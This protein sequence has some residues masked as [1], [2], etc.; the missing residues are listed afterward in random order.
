MRKRCSSLA[1]FLSTKTCQNVRER[2][3]LTFGTEVEGTKMS[4]EKLSCLKSEQEKPE[5]VENKVLV[6]KNFKGNTMSATHIPIAIKNLLVFRAGG[7][8]EFEGCNR[9][10]SV[11]GL[12]QIVYNDQ[13]IAHIIA[14]SPDG[15]RGCAD[16]ALYAKDINNLMLMCPDHHKLIDSDVKRFTVEYL[17]AMKKRHEDRVRQLLSI[18]PEKQRTVVLY[19]ANI[20]SLAS[21]VTKEM[22]R[23]AMW[24]D[25]YPSSEYPIELGYNNSSVYE[26]EESFWAHEKLNLENQVKDKVTRLR[27]ENKISKMALFA[28]APMPLLVRLGTLLPDKYDV[29]VYQ[30]HREPDT[31]KWL[32]EQVSDEFVLKR[33]EK[34]GGEACL[35]F[36]ISADIRNRVELQFPNAS[37][38]EITVPNPGLGFLRMEKQLSAFRQIT[39]MALKEI[40]DA[41]LADIK[42][43]M[44]MPNACAVEVG[45]VWMPKADLP[46]HLYDYNRSISQVDRYVFTIENF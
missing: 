10:L 4:G 22:A 20:G 27:E 29:E 24:P 13:Q 15:P 14:D 7:R 32:D 5:P 9:D 36:S 41:G 26:N 42:V 37:L 2:E 44:A 46:M 11:D 38:W 23:E 31:W 8:C 19:K 40:K 3:L 45:R 35:V 17:N 12:T 30:K 18:Q 39:R 43:F 34:V 25:Y 6:N 28:L 16:S 33:P 1:L 21:C